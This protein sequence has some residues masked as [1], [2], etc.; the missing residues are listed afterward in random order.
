MEVRKMT[1]RQLRERKFL[2]LAP[3]LVAPLLTILFRAFGGGTGVVAERSTVK[4]GFDTDLPPAHPAD[5][6]N[7]D[8]LSYYEHAQQ[9]SLALVERRKNEDNYAKR[10]GIGVDSPGSAD[11]QAEKLRRKMDALNKTIERGAAWG[12][13]SVQGSGSARERSEADI[14]RIEKIMGLGKK[15]TK[16]E[17]PEMAQLNGVLDKLIEAEH[18]GAAG[19]AGG[20]GDSARLR[21]KGVM[22]RETLGVRP[23]DSAEGSPV[24]EALAPDEQSLGSG[25]RLQ[26]ELGRDLFVGS[27]FIPRGTPVYGNTSLSGERLLATIR[28]VAWQGRLY[29]VLLQVYDQDGLEGI[30]IPG[31][32]GTDALRESADQQAGSLDVVSYSPTLAGQVAGAG[33]QTA[34]SLI[35]K[36]IRRVRVVVPADYRLIL[37]D[38]HKTNL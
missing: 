18:P 13:G 9:D 14:E 19:N 1:A 5:K 37:R 23:V 25:E 4:T 2:L 29:P 20:A 15:P 3:L 27:Q 6:K 26:L 22:E 33:I 17:D 10:V 12:S 21:A 36:K 11:V 30:Y 24:M 34:R 32:P 31:V 35:G 8:K 16:E 7:W 38:G 28:S